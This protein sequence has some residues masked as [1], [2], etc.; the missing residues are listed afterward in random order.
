MLATHSRVIIDHC[1]SSAPTLTMI[2][3]AWV[4]RW[5]STSWG[6]AT[7]PSLRTWAPSRP[8]WTVAPLQARFSTVQ[9]FTAAR[10]AA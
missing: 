5:A 4:T 9:S 8:F 10:S 3:L 7:C 1:T 6:G 2:T